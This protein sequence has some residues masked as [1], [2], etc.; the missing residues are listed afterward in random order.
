[1]TVSGAEYAPM[2]MLHASDSNE[3]RYRLLDIRKSMQDFE[4][5]DTSVVNRSVY[6]RMKQGRSDLAPYL[7]HG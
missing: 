6:D 5:G 1:M 7:R 3:G 4:Q 2:F